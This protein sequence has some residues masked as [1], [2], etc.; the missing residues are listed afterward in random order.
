MRINK[1]TKLNLINSRFGS[2]LTLNL[3]FSENSIETGNLGIDLSNERKIKYFH[4]SLQQMS[5]FVKSGSSEGE[6]FYFSKLDSYLANQD[7]SLGLTYIT[8]KGVHSSELNIKFTIRSPIAITPKLDNEEDIKILHSPFF[9]IDIEIKNTSKINQDI[10]TFIGFDMEGQFVNKNLVFDDK[11][12][13][14]LGKGKKKFVLKNLQPELE[15]Y[16][17]DEE[18]RFR[19]YLTT[20]Q[21]E[22]ETCLKAKYIY[23]GF[24]NEFVFLNKF[25][26]KEPYR[27]KFYYTK[28]FSS[29]DEV[30]EYAKNKH[31]EILERSDA[32]EHLL[33]S[34]E[35]PPEKKFLIAIAFRSFL[36]NTWLLISE[37]R[38]VEY[39]VW[40]GNF[41]MNSS[42]D[43]GMEVELLAKIFPWTLMLQLKEWKKYIT[44]N[45]A[46]K[47]KRGLV[48]RYGKN[49]EQV[50]YGRAT[51]LAKQ[52][53]ETMNSDKLREIIQDVLKNPQK[54]DLNKDGK[55]SPYE[56]NRGAAIEKAMQV[57]EGDLDLGHQDN[58]PH[59]LKA[60]L[61]RIAK[62]AMELYKMVDQFEYK[63]EVDFPH[64]WQAKIIKSKDALVSAKHYLD[65]ELKEPAIDNAVDIMVKE[66]SNK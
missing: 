46:K 48:K 39:Y 22:P 53:A 38:T 12:K 32:F 9:Y 58:E 35:A 44:I 3:N 43:V 45:K 2:R 17:L 11:G 34:Y 21:I 49:A 40:E 50:M 28:F 41:G 33:T 13:S 61:Y 25:Q 5:F 1:D 62:Y 37:M 52:T 66:D 6:G 19:G 51:K 36:A 4:Q 60:D 24:T 27:L 42:I 7:L 57:K 8:L 15:K 63:G 29:L 23:A 65:F 54:E 16:H 55:L 59:M 30:V 10:S 14:I 31:N 47:N 26:L 18:G 64:W 20:R 56:E